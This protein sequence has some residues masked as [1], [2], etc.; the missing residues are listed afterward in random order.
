MAGGG[1]TA[2]GRKQNK[3]TKWIWRRSKKGSTGKASSYAVEEIDF[4]GAAKSRI[5]F[6]TE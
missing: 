4:G 1:G 6:L 3:I 2:K 5:A